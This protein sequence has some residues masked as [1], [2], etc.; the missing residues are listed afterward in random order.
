LKLLTRYE[1]DYLRE[2][3]YGD[4][5]KMSKSRNPKRYVVEERNVLKVLEKY[6]QSIKVK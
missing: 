1:A 4:Y 6:H 3:G 2:K 5:V